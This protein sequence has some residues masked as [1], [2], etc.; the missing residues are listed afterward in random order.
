MFGAQTVFI[1][2]F[3]FCFFGAQ[4]GLIHKR[5]GISYNNNEEIEK[6][7]QRDLVFEQRSFISNF[8]RNKVVEK[9]VNLYKLFNG[10]TTNPNW[11]SIASAFVTT[12][13]S[14]GFSAINLFMNVVGN[15]FHIYDAVGQKIQRI[16]ERIRS[17][18]A[19]EDRYF[20]HLERQKFHS[21]LTTSMNRTFEQL[22][23]MNRAVLCLVYS[24][25]NDAQLRALRNQFCP[26]I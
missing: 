2:L 25:S 6:N 12:F 20:E 8:K 26:L 19:E 4:S 21:E 5:S 15:S 18:M 10:N 22:V 3:L 13:G 1:I 7:D 11:N 24:Q 16:E 9:L 14:N 17:R 23:S